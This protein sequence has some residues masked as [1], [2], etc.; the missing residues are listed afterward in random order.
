MD[1]KLGEDRSRYPK[2]ARAM[3]KT[4]NHS[5]N[6]TCSK[7]HAGRLPSRSCD[8]AETALWRCD[9]GAELLLVAGCRRSQNG[10]LPST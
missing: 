10:H 6:R 4:Y 3:T 9:L 2:S 1:E 7:N 5:V 8:S